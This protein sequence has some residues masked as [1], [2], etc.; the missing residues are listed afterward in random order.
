MVERLELFSSRCLSMPGHLAISYLA[1]N[2][3]VRAAGILEQRSPLACVLE[4]G[5]LQL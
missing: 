4:L 5:V 1:G 3:S 2:M